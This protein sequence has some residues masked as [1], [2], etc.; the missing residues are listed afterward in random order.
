MPGFAPQRLLCAVDLGPATRIILN[1]ARE[2]ARAFQAAVELVHADW[3]EPPRYFTAAQ[4]KALSAEERKRKAKLRAELDALAREVFQQEIRYAV[5]VIG[6]HPLPVLEKRIA[7]RS[8]DLV[9]LGSHG[10]S[11]FARLMLGSVAENIVREARQP[12]LIVRGPAKAPAQVRK[13]IC[14]VDFTASG[15]EGLDVS[16][17]L[18]GAFQAQ[19]DVVHAAEGPATEPGA[20][21]EKLC[22]WIPEAARGECRI[23]EV[24]RRG[25]AAEQ[26][27][28]LARER[29][30]N[31][32]VLGAERRPFLEF[33]T[34]GTTVE[35]VLRHSPCS[36]LVVPR[37]AP[38]KAR[39]KS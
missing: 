13:I 38:N 35:R 7:E 16:V 11:G 27:V 25:N 31:L 18:A 12:T 21:R 24:V 26:I 34:L 33:T 6:G 28:L 17:S 36:V 23:S 3:S 32:V 39:V 15:R 30:A 4:I 9:I 29:S 22:R 8:P 20:L 37:Q 1:W 5:R 2:F 19:L 14:P 10:R